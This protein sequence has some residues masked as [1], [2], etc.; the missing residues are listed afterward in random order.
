MFQDSTVVSSR[1]KY[2]SWDILTLDDTT[3]TSPP[4]VGYLQFSNVAPYPRKTDL[5]CPAVKA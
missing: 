3:T 2:S 1:S 4:D 5:N